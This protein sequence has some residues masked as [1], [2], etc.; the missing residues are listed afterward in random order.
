MSRTIAI[1]ILAAGASTRMG[2]SKQLLPVEGESLLRRSAQTA[3][4]TGCSPVVIVLGA[5]SQAHRVELAKLDVQIVENRDW[6]KGMGTSIRAGIEALPASVDAALIMLCDQPLVTPRLLLEFQI[7]EAG[8]IASEYDGTLGVPALFARKYF[9]ELCALPPESGA[10]KVIAAHRKEVDAVP[11][12]GGKVD[13]D[14]PD[15][16]AEFMYGDKW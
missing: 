2:R 5:N 11:F 13:L 16:V 8:I 14:T 10:K 3:L 6:E 9:P 7:R 15:D 4:R 12:P 1:I